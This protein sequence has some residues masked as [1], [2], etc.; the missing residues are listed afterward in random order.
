MQLVVI[1]VGNDARGDDALG[2]LL[3]D[4]V[5]KAGF[6]GVRAQLEF[7]LQVE[8][9]LD[10]SGAGLVLFIDAAH[11]LHTPYELSELEPARATP[12]FSHAL[13]PAAV[14]AVLEQLEGHAPPAFLLRVR[15]EQFG[16]GDSLSPL[17]EAALP[18]TWELLA[19][20]LSAPSLAAWRRLLRV[21]LPQPS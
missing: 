18:L 3:L 7:Q 10:I 20:L 9:A 21:Q 12:A 1:A 4:R 15:G 14:L 6:P 5:V 16:L 19:T 17:A 11:G 8:H 13:A 2:P